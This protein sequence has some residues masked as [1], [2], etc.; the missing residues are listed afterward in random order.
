MVNNVRLEK[1]KCEA[2]CGALMA[3]EVGRDDGGA[4]NVCGDDVC[5]DVAGE[6]SSEGW[7]RLEYLFI[8]SRFPAVRPSMLL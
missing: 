5:N 4:G 2:C 1:V 8:V 3:I 7:A 6:S